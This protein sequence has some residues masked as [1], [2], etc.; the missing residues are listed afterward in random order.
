MFEMRNNS[1]HTLRRARGDC[2]PGTEELAWQHIHVDASQVSSQIATDHTKLCV[3][4]TVSRHRISEC[5]LERMEGSVP[6]A[7]TRRIID[8]IRRSGTT[9]RHNDGI[10]EV[11]ISA[12]KRPCN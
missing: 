11:Q 2:M 5:D 6:A 3:S 12:L 4:S 10:V 9:R 8:Q 1:G 7:K